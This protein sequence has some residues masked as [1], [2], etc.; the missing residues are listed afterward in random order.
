[1]PLFQRL[2]NLC[3]VLSAQWI[4]AP[5]FGIAA[6]VKVDDAKQNAEVASQH[7]S[8]RRVFPNPELIDQDGHKVH[9]YDDVLKGKIFLINFIFTSCD[10]YCPMETARVRR[11]QD[12]LGD[13]MGKDIF[14]YSISIDPEND[15]PEALRAYRKK[16][17]AGPGWTFFTGNEAEITAMRRTI[18]LLVEDG[19]GIQKDHALNMLIG[20]ERAGQWMRRS[21]MDKAEVVAKLLSENLSEWRYN[22]GVTNDFAAAP[23]RLIPRPMGEE[24][25]KSRCADCHSIGGGR[26]IG[27]DLKNVTKIRKHD[28]LKLWIQAPN[29]ML[30][31]GDSIG[32][33]LLGQFNGLVMP[34]LGLSDNEIDSVIE[35]LRGANAA[36]NDSKIKKGETKR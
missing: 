33:S 22:V 3:L 16:F 4:F 21:N 24:I 28:W 9:F 5:S 14:F 15:T 2:K 30:S 27:P 12:L 8:S 23:T 1:M 10:A 6:D 32:T 36:A 31:K 34:N 7:E 29:K 18:G 25:Y 35:Y 11:I 13:R 19:D 17:G 20:N 26:G